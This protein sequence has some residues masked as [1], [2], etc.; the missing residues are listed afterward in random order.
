MQFL[1]NLHVDDLDGNTLLQGAVWDPNDQ[2][3]YLSQSRDAGAIDRQHT[4]I[5]RFSPTGLY[6]GYVQLDLFGHGSVIGYAD[7]H[8]WLPCD[9]YDSQG[10]TLRVQAARIDV[11]R[12]DFERRTRLTRTSPALELFTTGLAN[13]LSPFSPSGDDLFLRWGRQRTEEY[14]NVALSEF[15]TQR[16]PKVL[17]RISATKA[18]RAGSFQGC[19][20][21]GDWVY[22][23]NGDTDKINKVTSWSWTD[24]KPGPVIE[25]TPAALRRVLTG[26]VDR[27]DVVE[28]EG[29]SWYEGELVMGVRTGPGG[30]SRDFAL[31]VL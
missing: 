6:Q 2:H 23:L 8:L 14:I 9:F 13:N 5:H 22:V 30:R 12:V 19:T 31:V 24:P 1:L 18:G 16:S 20:T 15:T 4:R 7:G 11:S 26:H 27:P 10:K 3:W 29:L 25:V 28:P 21:A 17:S